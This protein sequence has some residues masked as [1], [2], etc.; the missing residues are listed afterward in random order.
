M[1]PDLQNQ[2]RSSLRNFHQGVCQ[3]SKCELP[4]RLNSCSIG[5]PSAQTTSHGELCWAVN[6]VVVPSDRLGIHILGHDVVVRRQRMTITDKASDD[7]VV[8]LPLNNKRTVILSSPHCVLDPINR[9]SSG[10]TGF[11][12]KTHVCF[13]SAFRR[14]RILLRQIAHKPG[15]SHQNNAPKGLVNKAVVH[16]MC[17]MQKGLGNI[18]S[19]RRKMKT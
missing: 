6:V 14:G 8:S 12:C 7:S 13:C 1:T 3:S 2:I 18:A 15:N 10:F 5:S 17:E 16:W 11:S 19:C 9:V 4:E